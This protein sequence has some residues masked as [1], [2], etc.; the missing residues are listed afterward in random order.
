[1]SENI[2]K[3]VEAVLE[4][5]QSSIEQNGE[6]NDE[7]RKILNL[8]FMKL[9][10]GEKLIEKFKEIFPEVKFDT[11]RRDSMKRRFECVSN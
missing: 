2:F 9:P 4:K 11:S 6:I 10:N 5:T 7:D 1:M 8:E 3:S